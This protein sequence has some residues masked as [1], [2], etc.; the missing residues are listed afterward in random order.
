MDSV[1]KDSW[2]CSTG[3]LRKCSDLWLSDMTRP[4]PPRGFKFIHADLTYTYVFLYEY[5][6]LM[7]LFPFS[8]ITGYPFGRAL[9]KENPVDGVHTNDLSEAQTG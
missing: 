8:L 2:F 1:P 4:H 7:L 5:L 6:D 3:N 9:L